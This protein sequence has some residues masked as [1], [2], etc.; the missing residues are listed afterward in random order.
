MAPWQY[1]TNAEAAMNLL[2]AVA[3]GKKCLSASL[4]VC[5]TLQTSL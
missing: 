5:P 2:V 3:T 1:T 4:V